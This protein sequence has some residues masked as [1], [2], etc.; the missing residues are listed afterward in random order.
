VGGK[1]KKS[2]HVETG[3]WGCLG[4]L[5]NLKQRDFDKDEVGSLGKNTQRTWGVPEGKKVHYTNKKREVKRVRKGNY[6]VIWEEKTKYTILDSG[7][8]HQE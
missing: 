7:K 8:S 1:K 2:R 6:G 4:D 3:G 5:G